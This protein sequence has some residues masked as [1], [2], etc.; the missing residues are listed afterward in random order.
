[1]G[2]RKERTPVPRGGKPDPPPAP[3]TR[4]EIRRSLPA[5]SS[6]RFALAAL[7]EDLYQLVSMTMG[8][9]TGVDRI[10]GVT[11]VYVGDETYCATNGSPD[12]DLHSAISE[13]LVAIKRDKGENDV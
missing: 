3:T 13:A 2:N 4:R 1:M 6:E 8:I 7:K 9:P 10:N 5:D 12:E 11:Y